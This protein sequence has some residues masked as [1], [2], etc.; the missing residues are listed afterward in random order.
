MAGTLYDPVTEEVVIGA[1]CRLSDGRETLSDDFGD[2]WFRD[3]PEAAYTLTI[4]ASGFAPWHSAPLSTA[5]Q[6]VN[7]GDIPLEKS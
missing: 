7:L 2:F 5:G 4:E 1:R 6:D 3:L